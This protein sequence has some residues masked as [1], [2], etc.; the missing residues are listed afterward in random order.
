[1]ATRRTR[2]EKY[3]DTK[4]FHYY[5]ANPKNR[6][7]TDCVIRAIATATEQD[8]NKTVMELAQMQCDTGYDDGDKKLYDKYL[9]SKGWKKCSQPRKADNTKYTGREFCKQIKEDIVWATNGEHLKHIVANIGGNHVVAIIDGKVW[10]IWD[11]T[12]GCIGN[13]WIKE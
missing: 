10:D 2:Q 3:P 8:Y 9:Q 6:I 4:T 7:T 1:M 11:S 13:Y 12:D 5:N